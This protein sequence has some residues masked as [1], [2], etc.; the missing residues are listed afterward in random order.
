MLLSFFGYFQ[1]GK[2]LL[3]PCQ[4]STWSNSAT[5]EFRETSTTVLPVLLVHYWLQSVFTKTKDG[6]LWQQVLAERVMVLQKTFVL[7]KQSI[8][9]LWAIISAFYTLL[10]L[11]YIMRVISRAASCCVL[12]IPHTHLVRTFPALR[13]TGSVRRHVAEVRIIQRFWLHVPV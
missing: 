1:P 6:I 13:F 11:S 8:M 10:S 9:P 3:W 7:E 4:S 2:L 12:L 5:N